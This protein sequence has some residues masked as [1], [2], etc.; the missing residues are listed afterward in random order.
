M[1]DFYVGEPLLSE[2]LAIV[3]RADHPLFL[4]AISSCFVGSCSGAIW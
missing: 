4:P 3:A 1:T 2:E